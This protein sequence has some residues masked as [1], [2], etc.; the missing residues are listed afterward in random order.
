MDSTFYNGAVTGAVRR[1]GVLPGH[2]PD[3][4]QY[5]RCDRR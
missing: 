4:Q 2:R 3:E 5:P 1:Q